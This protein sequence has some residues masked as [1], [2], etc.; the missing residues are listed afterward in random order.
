LI[1][2][3]LAASAAAW[4]L[5]HIIDA[6]VIVA[7][8]VINAIVGFIQEG[9]AEQA[10]EAIRSMIAPRASVL[11]GG[12]RLSLPATELVPGDVVL[13]EAGDQVPADLRL[14]RTRALLIEEAILTGESVAAEKQ[15]A[16]VAADAAL[17]DRSC[18]AFS[19]TLVAAGPGVGVVAATGTAAELGRISAHLARVHG[20][21]TPLLRHV[22]Q[23]R[24]RV[25]AVAHGAA[26]HL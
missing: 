9:R 22:N 13:L 18:M 25:P 1:Y 2:F 7:V 11:R 14:V 5:G 8:V 21:T 26:G 17:G 6:G 20:L 3:L 23:C 19:G 15:D 12:K 4:T 16:P 10:L 24:L